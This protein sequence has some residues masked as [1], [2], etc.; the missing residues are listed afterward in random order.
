[1]RLS[2]R[3][4]VYDHRF[5]NAMQTDMLRRAKREFLACGVLRGLESAD[6]TVPP[7]NF[8]VSST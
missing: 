2:I 1:M 8:V 6:G 4:H 7:K 5:E 3:A